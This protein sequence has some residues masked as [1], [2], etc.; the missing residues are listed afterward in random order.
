MSG[1]PKASGNPGGGD[2]G[3][4]RQSRG[5]CDFRVRGGPHSRF[6]AIALAILLAVFAVRCLR[7]DE[8]HCENAVAQ[9]E[10]CCPGF[11]VGAEYCVHQ[12][13]CVDTF[14]WDERLPA[15]SEADARCIANASCSSLVQRGTCERAMQQPDPDGVLPDLCP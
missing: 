1:P 14:T 7:S 10:R 4:R 5:C 8:L 15:I 3:R 13:Q 11:A 9:L 6:S 12:D 2:R